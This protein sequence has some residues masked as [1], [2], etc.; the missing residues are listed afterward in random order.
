MP[1]EIKTKQSSTVMC[2][3]CGAEI[4]K[5]D[6]EYAYLN[7]KDTIVCTNCESILKKC[8]H[9]GE[10]NIED[11][12][13]STSLADGTTVELC[14]TC[15]RDEYAECEDCRAYDQNSNMNDFCIRGID[16]VVCDGCYDEY[17]RC[18]ECGDHEH[19]DDSC[20]DD[21][22][23]YCQSCFE[24]NYTVCEHCGETFRFDTSQLSSTCSECINELYIEC[25]NCSILILNDNALEY[26]DE[27]YCR[28]CYDE[29]NPPQPKKPPSG[30]EYNFFHFKRP[31]GIEIECL[32]DQSRSVYG[33]DYWNTTYDGSIESGEQNGTELYSNILYGDDVKI[34]LDDFDNIS[35]MT[36][37]DT[38]DSCGVHIHVGLRPAN[39]KMS[40][41]SFRSGAKPTEKTLTDDEQKVW[42]NAW[43][44]ALMWSRIEPMMFAICGEKRLKNQ[45][46]E[47]LGFAIDSKDI[48]SISSALEFYQLVMGNFAFSSPEKYGCGDHAITKHNPRRCAINFNSLAY[49]G[50]IE[51]RSME[52][53]VDTQRIFDWAYLCSAIVESS[54]KLSIKKIKSLHSYNPKRVLRSLNIPKTITNRIMLRLKKYANQKRRYPEL[55]WMTA[56]LN[57]AKP[58][59]DLTSIYILSIQNHIDTIRR[60]KQSC[61]RHCSGYP[62]PTNST[63]PM[64]MFNSIL[65]QKKSKLSRRERK[66]TALLGIILNDSLLAPTFS[67]YARKLRKNDIALDSAIKT[68]EALRY[69]SFRSISTSP[70]Q[71]FVNTYKKTISKKII[72]T[73]MGDIIKNVLDT[74]EPEQKPKPITKPALCV[75]HSEVTRELTN[76]EVEHATR[77]LN[78][79][80]EH[81]TM[82][83]ITTLNEAI[84]EPLP[85]VR[86]YTHNETAPEPA[87]IE[88][89][90]RHGDNGTWYIPNS[91]PR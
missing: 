26:E 82:R 39:T 47:A 36:E 13:E 72:C 54:Q 5:D 20:S 59:T 4:E 68:L 25:Y 41:R 10:L 65:K 8:D 60:N 62:P 35:E 3:I 84:P 27:Y 40:F 66:A 15:L 16:K 90:I 87:P 30:T 46:S 32:Y 80:T 55:H 74:T 64:E 18:E 21:N 61:G 51:F 58:N 37:L 1:A 89:T 34:A 52:G 48:A 42:L 86:F 14:E 81:P 6:A 29:L 2:E 22:Q 49:R 83:W 56:L 23:T 69:S 12:L 43:K 85:P 33:T 79:I 77:T 9:C 91:R 17:V 28:S 71:N 75:P 78:D 7:E 88:S 73:S 53:T 57:N 24:E 50:S 63:G 45:Y 31:V 44:V 38:N 19:I 76:S 70:Y 11:S 67:L